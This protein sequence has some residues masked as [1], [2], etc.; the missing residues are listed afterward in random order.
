MTVVV[1]TLVLFAGLALTGC[2]KKSEKA[3]ERDSD[4]RKPERDSATQSSS[5]SSEV[6]EE[7]TD[8]R[9][10]SGDIA[11]DC[12]AFLSAT[13]APSGK[14][15]E[16]ACPTCPTSDQ[17]VEV[18]KFDELKIDRIALSGATCQVTARIF[19]TFNPS[20]GGVITGGLLGWIPAEQREDYARGK[21][22]TGQQTYKLNITYRRDANGW[23]PIDFAPAR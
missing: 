15:S 8:E 13:K 10:D 9:P 21:A 14:S 3:I 19:A 20:K 11:E 6:S 17:G 22:P 5:V 23:Q 4:A 1:A 2:S 18:L 12:V 7:E 16:S